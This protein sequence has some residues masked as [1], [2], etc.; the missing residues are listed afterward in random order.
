M[1]RAG[2]QPSHPPDPCRAPTGLS[3]AK[4]SL[5]QLSLQKIKQGL[6]TA[7]LLKLKRQVLLRECWHLFFF[8][9]GGFYLSIFGRSRLKVKVSVKLKH[10]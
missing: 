1:L 7:S 5:I 4:P 10:A 9:I 8:L 3:H 6:M 2:C